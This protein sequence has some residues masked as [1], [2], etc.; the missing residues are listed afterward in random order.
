MFQTFGSQTWNKFD[1]FK[2]QFLYK[3]DTLGQLRSII[4]TLNHLPL[5]P[6]AVEGQFGAVSPDRHAPVNCGDPL[7]PDH[8]EQE[9]S[10][11]EPVNA[12]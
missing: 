6:Q 1:H 12:P 3:S 5:F 11:N 10:V 8:C 4:G 2:E 9:T 7:D